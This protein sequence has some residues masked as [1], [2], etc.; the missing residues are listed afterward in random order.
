MLSNTC[1]TAIKAVIYIAGQSEK[2]EK[3]GIREVSQGIN[4]SE[5][6]VGKILQVLVKHQLIY[7]IKGPS[8]GFFIDKHQEVRPLIDI[9]YAIDGPNVFKGCGL[10][11]SKCST[12]HPCPIHDQYK[13]ARDLIEKIFK[14]N[15][16]KTLC[17]PIAEGLAHLLDWNCVDIVWQ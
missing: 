17:A 5:H 4:A 9:V 1:K 15:T 11:L 13:I 12:S 10:G 2:N 14:E 16:L 8:G 7:S 3:S 6:T